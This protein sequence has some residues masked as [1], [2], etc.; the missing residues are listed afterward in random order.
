MITISKANTIWAFSLAFLLS[1]C[2][3]AQNAPAELIEITGFQSAQQSQEPAAEGNPMVPPQQSLA[4][5]PSPIEVHSS[6]DT[7]AG[8]ASEIFI[9]FDP[10]QQTTIFQAPT[11]PDFIPQTSEVP[12]VVYLPSADLPSIDLPAAIFLKD[13]GYTGPGDMRTHLWRDH[14]SDLQGSGISHETLMS[15]PMESVQKWHNYFHGTEDSPAH[16]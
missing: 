7:F 3:L 8:Q 16:P 6:V 5:D 13:V 9:E 12:G 14:A 10:S 2:A 1:H 4:F 15:M 11:Q